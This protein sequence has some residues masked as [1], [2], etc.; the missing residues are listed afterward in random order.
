VLLPAGGVAQ[1]SIVERIERRLQSLN[2]GSR[3]QLAPSELQRL[4]DRLASCWNLPKTV[5]D[6]AGLVVVVDIRLN[7]DGSLAS[8]P[9]V[10]NHSDNPKFP[11]AA[12]S[13]TR[14]V[15][16][17]AP[18]SFLPA[19]KYDAWKE[20]EVNFDAHEFFGAPPKQ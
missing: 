7:A 13:V 6:A 10:V 16:Q 3:A 5:R 17:C 4:R 9:Q 11:V 8:P 12:E 18:F 2:D 19:A 15:T 20:I 14:A 1:D